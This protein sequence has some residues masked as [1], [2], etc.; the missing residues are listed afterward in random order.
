MTRSPKEIPSQKV[1]IWERY[2]ALSEI[3]VGRFPNHLLIIPDGNRRFAET[4]GILPVE[5]HK[6]GLEVMVEILRDMHELPISFITLWAFSRDNWKR[7][8]EEVSGLM[9]LL[10]E[11]VRT[12]IGQL[13]EKN[14]RFVHLGRKD[15]I[16]E[17]LRSAI[18]EAEDLTMKNTGQTVCVAIDFGGRDQELRILKKVV[19]AVNLGEIKDES[20]IDEKYADSLRDA[21]GLIPPADLLIR[22]SG[23]QRTSDIGWLNGAQTELF[24]HEKLFPELTTGDIVDALLNFSKRQRRFGT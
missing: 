3:P 21:D 11:G 20:A 16:P 2:P 18:E 15:R 23:E 4:Q 22:S 19:R 8:P 7:P 12:N 6:L 9:T 5:G 13:H 10:T 14:T 24:I 1:S 17:E